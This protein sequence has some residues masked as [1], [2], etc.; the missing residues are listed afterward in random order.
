MISINLAEHV[1]ELIAADI[2][3]QGIDNDNVVVYMPF[4]YDDGDQFT[5]NI[6]RAAHNKWTLSDEGDALKRAGEL[7][8]D[9]RREE[10]AD[11]LRKLIE[12]YGI[13]G[14]NGELNL[15]TDDHGLVKSLF[16]LTQTCLETSWLAKTPRLSER[17]EKENFPLKFERLVRKAIP[18]S[19]FKQ[20]WHDVKHDPK[21]I[22]PVDI[23]I[24][25]KRKQLFLFGIAH[26]AACMR[27]TITCQHYRIAGADFEAVAIYD[28]EEQI[29]K[30]YSDQLNEVVDKRFPR[31]A[32]SRAITS[33]L[34]E[35]A[36]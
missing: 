28:H 19:E 2:D 8:F 35:M 22:Y 34:R 7:G 32:E 29:T 25:G 20:D 17:T 13:S 30:R 27:A 15:K 3:V 12:F 18:S 10:N 31:V 4:I 21:R 14:T 33:Y 23:H 1:R 9:Y 11:R 5:V 36:A 6:S 26:Q 24:P 16:T